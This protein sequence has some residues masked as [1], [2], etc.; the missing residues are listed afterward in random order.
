MDQIRTEKKLTDEVEE[1][2]KKIIQLTVEEIAI[3]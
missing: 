2:M 3:A 1:Q